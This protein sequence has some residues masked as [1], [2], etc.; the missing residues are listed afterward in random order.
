MKLI[1]SLAIVA[2]LFFVASP[3]AEARD[4]DCDRGY[5]GSSHRSYDDCDR[6]YR[7]HSS[8]RGHYSSGYRESYRPVYPSYRRDNCDRRGV[9]VF[10]PGIGYVVVNR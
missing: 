1:S 9:S 5:R 7:G 10:I 4:R 2:G 6:G 8:Y 3:K